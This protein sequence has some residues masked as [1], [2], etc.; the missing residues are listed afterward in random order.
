MSAEEA[1]TY[2]SVQD[3]YGKVLKTSK[4]LKTSACTASKAPHP[5]VRQLIKEVPKEVLE[6]FYGCGAPLPLG[7]EGRRVLDLGSG[8]GRDCYVCSSLV[9]EKGKV[10]GID[11][12]DEQLSVARQHAGE[13]CKKL[14]YSEPNL[15]FVQGHIEYLDKAGLEDESFDLV[16]SNCVVNLS[17]DKPRVLREVYRVL[18]NGGEFYFSD[19]Y[20]DRRI[21]ADVQAHQVLW[22]ECISGAMYIEDFLRESVK[23]GFTDP[24][25][26]SMEEIIIHDPVLKD[27]VGRA[28][29]YSITYRL[30]KLPGMLESKCEDYGQYAVY[31]GT[32]PGFPHHY[33]LDD[34]HTLEKNKP[35]LVCG[36]TGAMLGENQVS[37]LSPHFDIHGDRSVHYGLFDCGGGAPAAPAAAAG[38][39]GSCC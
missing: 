37:W 21:P 20:A 19:V 26:L 11:M 8:S 6:K 14:G 5:V 35:F 12:T 9:G 3:Y 25:M 1:S 15:S 2:E 23:V 16:I 17:P 36:N 18:A 22:G 33:D 24:R 10:V 34:H 30:F 39:G 13:Y 38:G 32:I 27:V 31:K 29:F 4:D 28:R 7:I